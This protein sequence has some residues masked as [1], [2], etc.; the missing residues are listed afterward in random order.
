[1]NFK[2]PLVRPFAKQLTIAAIFV[3]CGLE[4]VA[5]VPPPM[6]EVEVPAGKFTGLPIHWDASSAI[7]IEPAGGFLELNVADVRQHRI[8]SEAFQPQSIPYARSA[9][10]AE[11]GGGFETAVTG[12]YVIVAPRGHVDRWRDRFRTLLAGYARYFDVRGWK[13]REPAFPLVV[14]VLPDRASFRKSMAAD[15]GRSSNNVLGYYSPKTNRCLL[16]EIPSGSN[17]N[18]S[19]TEATIVHEAIH[20]LAFNTGVHERLAENPIWIVEGLATMF[21]RP[22]VYEAQVSSSTIPLRVN[23]GQLVQLKPLLADAA[24][25]E[26]LLHSMIS[27]D[28]LFKADPPTA[29]A[30]AWGLTFYLAERDPNNYGEYT[31]RVSQLPILK[32][33]SPLERV[34]EFQQV[35]GAELSMISL[36]MQRF[37][38]NL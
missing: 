21:E 37:F 15:T 13:L 31:R 28:E 2:H 25:L 4:A 36:Q 7:L 6:M 8:T 26:L 11:F 19:E 9:V 16:F 22:A 32:A 5:Q 33:Y 29:Y 34:Q 24:R 23:S 18:W 27:S 14:T 35:F 30:L 10:Q 38:A 20:Q 17:T 1:M 12:P 3:A